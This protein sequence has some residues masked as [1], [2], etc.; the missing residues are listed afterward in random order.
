MNILVEVKHRGKKYFL[1]M[2]VHASSIDE[3]N[4]KF[5][6]GLK[7]NGRCAECK[8]KPYSDSAAILKD[9]NEVDDQFWPFYNIY[10]KNKKT[11]DFFHDGGVVRE[12]EARFLRGEFAKNIAESLREYFKAE[13]SLC[14]ECFMEKYNTKEE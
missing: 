9:K 6:L 12:I 11:L 10:V 13:Y 1:E 14:D 2:R 8:V 7:K 3:A 4:R 5:G